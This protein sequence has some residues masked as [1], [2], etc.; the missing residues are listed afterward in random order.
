MAAPNRGEKPESDPQ[1]TKDDS[2]SRM[3]DPPELGRQVDQVSQSSVSPTDRSSSGR[4]LFNGRRMPKHAGIGAAR[5]GKQSGADVEIPTGD[6]VASLGS[7]EAEV[8]GL[9]WEIGQPS[10]GME[11]MEKSLYKA[12]ALGQEPVSFS[13]IA[14]TLRRLA[15]KGLL[16]SQK[17]DGR[18]PVFWPTVEREQ[19]AARILN[20]VSETLLGTSLHRLLP[21]LIGRAK[22]KLG[23]SDKMG[24]SDEDQQVQ[25]L[26]RALEEVAETAAKLSEPPQDAKKAAPEAEAEKSD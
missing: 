16:S 2:H 4:S 12:R 11:L 18:T 23:S 21:M 17:I 1:R 24:G 8:L 5:R 10:T 7:L 19:M 20:N 6:A 26:M 25:R 13:T 15:G 14:T 9:L 22:Q 3:S